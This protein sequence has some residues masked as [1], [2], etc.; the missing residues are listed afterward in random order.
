MK[1]SG[2]GALITSP[3]R[4][5]AQQIFEVL[6]PLAQ[7]SELSIGALMGGSKNISSKIKHLSKEGK[8]R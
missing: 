4:E 7:A 6:K 3:T 8:R 1:L 5:L 2:V